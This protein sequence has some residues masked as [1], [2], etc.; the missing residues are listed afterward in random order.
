M[1]SVFPMVATLAVL[2]FVGF[3]VYSKVIESRLVVPS[4]QPTPAVTINDGVD[5]VPARLPVLFGHHFSSIAGAG[6]IIGPIVVLAAFGWLPAL[7]WIVAGNIFI[8]AVHD[9]LALMLSVRHGGASIA[10]IS[11]TALGER[12]ATIFSVFLWLAMILVVAVFGVVGAKTLVAKPEMVIPTLVLI[13]TAMALGWAVYRKGAPLMLATLA[14]LIVNFA[15]IWVGYLYPVA[16]EGTTWG[17]DPIQFWFVALMIYAGTAAMMPVHWLLQPRD[18]LATYNLYIALGLGIVGLIVVHPTIQAPAFT[19]MVDATQGPLWPMLFILIACGAISG[20]HA[21]VA[22][23]TTSKQLPSERAGRL[24][25]YG[26]MLTEGVLATMTLMLVAGGLYWVLPEGAPA[27]YGFQESMAAGGWIVVFGN[28]FGRVVHEMLPF[29]SVAI[30][31]MIA[32]IALNT[33]IL[34]TLD[35]ATRITRFLVQESVGRRIPLFRNPSVAL[36]LVLVPAF[37]IGATNSWVTIWPVFGATNQLIAVMALFV[38]STVLLAQGRS[39]RFTLI[40]AIFMWVTTM[41]ALVWQSYSFLTAEP[42]NVF[43]GVVALLLLGL[44]LYIGVGALRKFGG[45]PVEVATQTS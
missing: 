44:A 13:P 21:L 33:F 8:G 38:I 45:Q 31:A 32:M 20:F 5:Y 16:V 34:T 14:A 35:T 10:E 39:V 30:A 27:S 28:A 3:R 23:G 9:Y 25:G 22:G 26:G 7:L 36:A 11:R 42:S 1:N 24:I 6:P 15:S 12:A 4:D 17:M 37:L 2:Y 18:Y 40:P 43:L 29:V 41:G 19:G